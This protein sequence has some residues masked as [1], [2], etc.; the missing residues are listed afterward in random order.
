MNF[1]QIKESIIVAMFSDDELM[2]RFVLKGGTA[3]DLVYPRP[4]GRSSIDIDLSMKDDFEETQLPVV[5]KRIEE[6]LSREFRANGYEVID[7]DLKSRPSKRSDGLPDFWGGY[8]LQFK[9]V[10]TDIYQKLINKKEALRKQSETVAGSQQRKF[11]I[12][13]SKYE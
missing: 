11:K 1:E 12:D 9:L 13:I 2:E 5:K 8:S 6:L 7:C 10:Q 3:L 4:S